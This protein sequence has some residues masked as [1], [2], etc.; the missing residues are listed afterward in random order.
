MKLIDN[1]AQH[2]DAGTLPESFT[3]WW[4]IED[5]DREFLGHPFDSEINHD[6]M[7]IENGAVWY[8]FRRANY[9]LRGGRRIKTRTKKDQDWSD[10]WEKQ[11]PEPLISQ[12]R[13]LFFR[14]NKIDD[15]IST[16]PDRIAKLEKDVADKK[17][18]I[19][20]MK[21]RIKPGMSD[22]QIQVAFPRLEWDDNWN[23]KSLIWD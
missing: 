1:F 2:L 17:D 16:L 8:E 20:C 13:D 18:F 14:L 21:D 19:A 4:I 7:L 23:E 9:E 3:D 6:W 12:A 22:A 15:E 10:L 11:F 5:A